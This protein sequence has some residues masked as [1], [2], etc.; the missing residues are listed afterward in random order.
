VQIVV[1]VQNTSLY[2]C[3]NN[4]IDS[5]TAYKESDIV[6]LYLYNMGIV[7][8]TPM[9]LAVVLTKLT[10]KW[11]FSGSICVNSMACMLKY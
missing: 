9:I 4:A 7:V 10:G 8:I 1:N 3:L 5:L 2:S 11:T 6:G